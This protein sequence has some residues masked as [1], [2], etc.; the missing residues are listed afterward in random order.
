[1]KADN[2]STFSSGRT[3]NGLALRN[4]MASRVG[5]S[6][7]AETGSGDPLLGDGFLA[8]R[9]SS[10]TSN[11]QD[12]ESNVPSLWSTGRWN[13]KPDLQALSTGVIARPIFDGLPKPMTVRR[14]A[15]LD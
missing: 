14:K 6:S 2:G 13:L 11:L 10:S 3:G 7:D 1:M 9:K 4:K 5:F 15:A 12:S 8:V